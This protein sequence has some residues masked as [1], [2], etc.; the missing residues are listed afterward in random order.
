[1]YDL[2]LEDDPANVEALTYRGWMLRLDGLR[3]PDSAVFAAQLSDGLESLLTAADVDPTY[4]DPQC[5][6]GVI[7]FRDLG[8]ADDA[9]E[10]LDVCLE[11]DPPADVR[12]LVEG[13]RSE[14]IAA[15]EA[16]AE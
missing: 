2:V 9:L 14:V 4:A 13:L 16:G 12:G 5:F 11:L 10:R 15:I 7:L 8:Q 1:V 3:Q 6:L